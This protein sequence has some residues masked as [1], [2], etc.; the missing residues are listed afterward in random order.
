MMIDAK[1]A[2]FLDRTRK[3]LWQREYAREILKIS[4]G[5]YRSVESGRTP[6][7]KNWRI[8]KVEKI[9]DLE[10]YILL[11]RRKGWTKEQ[12]GQQI[13]NKTGIQKKGINRFVPS[14]YCTNNQLELEESGHTR[15]HW[16]PYFWGDA[17]L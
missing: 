6:V 14:E 2:L 3:G 5:T 17:T 4:E 13:R 7:P 16:L 15:L 8:P 9:T 11:R 1:E 12:L 10:K